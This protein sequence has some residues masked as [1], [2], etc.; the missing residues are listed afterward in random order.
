MKKVAEGSGVEWSKQ[1]RIQQLFRWTFSILLY[2][3]LRLVV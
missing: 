2:K 1:Q 3:L